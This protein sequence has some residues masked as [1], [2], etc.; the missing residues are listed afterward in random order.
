MLALLR[1]HY[2]AIKQ[3]TRLNRRSQA[4]GATCIVGCSEFN[5]NRADNEQ[6]DRKIILHDLCGICLKGVSCLARKLVVT[7]QPRALQGIARPSFMWLRESSRRL[8]PMPTTHFSRDGTPTHAILDVCKSRA[9]CP[10]VQGTLPSVR[11]H[12]TA[13]PRMQAFANDS[14]CQHLNTPAGS[15]AQPST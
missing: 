1:L 2:I 6:R 10:P 4:S 8:S 14:S 12:I 15:L 13:M 5:L 9:R 3:T 11:A 7:E